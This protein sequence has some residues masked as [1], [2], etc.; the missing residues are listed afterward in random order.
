MDKKTISA[1]E[2]GR[3]IYC[4]Y[5]WYYEKS[6]GT[7]ELR[8][9][10]KEYLDKLDLYPDTIDD[11]D[12]PVKSKTPKGRPRKASPI[13]RGLEY[14]ANFGRNSQT[15]QTESGKAKPTEHIQQPRQ[16]RE[17]NET[18]Q[19]IKIILTIIITLIIIYFLSIGGLI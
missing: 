18:K 4:N 17:I 13:K 5:Q 7:A 14:H 10:K 1:S 2:I 19:I 12:S 11:S 6:F 3:Y 8:R 9:R 16:Q 15:A